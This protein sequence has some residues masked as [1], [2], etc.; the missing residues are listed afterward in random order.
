MKNITDI[1]IL[2]LST[3]ELNDVVILNHGFEEYMRDY[4]FII[5][6]GTKELGTGRYKILFT[7]CFDLTYHHKFAD[8]QHPDLLR[9]SWADD[10]I[11]D[12]PPG[13]DDRYWWGQGFTTT[14]PGFSYDSESIKAKEMSEITGRPMY[15]VRMDGNHYEMNFIFHDFHYSLL[16]T[17]TLVTRQIHIPPNEFNVNKK[18]D[19]P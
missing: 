7:H 9:R 10:L 15:A 18:T 6:S 1:P 5:E 8:I 14:F 11:L 3:I 13:N 19:L 17:D 2:A 16:S 12:K 4:Y